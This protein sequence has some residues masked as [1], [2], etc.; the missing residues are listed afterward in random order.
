[1]LTNNRFIFS[2]GGFDPIRSPSSS[3]V[4]GNPARVG[5]AYMDIRQP[6]LSQ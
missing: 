5:S 6:L 3:I 2:S 4:V 1:M